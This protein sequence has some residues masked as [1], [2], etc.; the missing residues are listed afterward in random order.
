MLPGTDPTGTRTAFVM[1][2]TAAVLIPL[3]LVVREAGVGG[4]LSAAGAALAGFYF[5]QQAI[6]FG[7][8]R[9]HQAAKRVLRASLLYLPV[10]F[11]LLLLEKFVVN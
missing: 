11:G 6:R 4:W 9:T 1:I 10:V 2:T 5:T 8:N 3:G 7:R